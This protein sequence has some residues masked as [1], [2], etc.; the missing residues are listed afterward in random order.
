MDN[1]TVTSVVQDKNVLDDKV[2]RGPILRRSNKE[3]KFNNWKVGDKY[4]LEKYL[5]SGSYG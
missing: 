1:E 2:K 3:G 4:K 5:G